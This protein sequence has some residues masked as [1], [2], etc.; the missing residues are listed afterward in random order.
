MKASVLS[1]VFLSG[2]AAAQTTIPTCATG[3]VTQF[4]T[5]SSIAGCG[6]LDIKCICQ[7]ADFLSGIACCL[8]SACDQSAQTQA[9]AYAKQ[10]CSS[11]GVSVPDQVVCNEKSS[12]STSE[13]PKES[14]TAAESSTSTAKTESS[15]SSK[16]GSSES[17]TAAESTSAPATTGSASQTTGTTAAAS[18]TTS[19][20]RTTSSNVA[21]PLASAGSFVGAAIAM[22]A[23]AL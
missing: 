15:H 18:Q 9:V 5:G 6:Q 21:A 2:L 12:S 3:C 19:A 13:A 22:L 14:S 10:I 23:A 1:L 20:A 16:T 11:A 8:A 7:N 17:T 4:T